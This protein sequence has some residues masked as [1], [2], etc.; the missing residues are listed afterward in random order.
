[1][2][3]ALSNFA[4]CYS[5]IGTEK[6]PSIECR[7]G[8]KSSMKKIIS[9]N[10]E[11][12]ERWDTSCFSFSIFFYLIGRRPLKANKFNYCYSGLETWNMRTCARCAAYSGEQFSI[13]LGIKI[14]IQSSISLLDRVTYREL[15]EICW[16]LYPEL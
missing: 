3:L 16:Y 5:K 10:Q 15:V 1:M 8:K 12:I 6:Y 14:L 9:K 13:N 2:L 11:Q 4:W 7:N